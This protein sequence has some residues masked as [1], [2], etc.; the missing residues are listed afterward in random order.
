MGLSCSLRLTC[1]RVADAALLRGGESRYTHVQRSQRLT[2]PVLCAARRLVFSSTGDLTRAGRARVHKGQPSFVS[3]V[4][5]AAEGL[6][7]VLFPSDCRICG[8]PLVKISRLP[9]CDDCLTRMQPIVEPVCGTCGER[10]PGQYLIGQDGI[11]RCNECRDLEPL[12]AKAL[13]YGSYDSGLRELIHLLKYEQV[14]PAASVL[15]RMLAEAIAALRLPS[16]APPLAVPVPLHR[17]KLRQRGFNQSELIARA[18]L[19]LHPAG[20]EFE[21]RAQ[22]LQRVRSTLSQTGL[23][24]PQRVE[25]MRGAFAVKEDVSGR[26]VLLLDDV[27]TTGTTVSEC[28]RVLRRAGAHRVWV[29]TVARVLKVEAAFADPPM[30]E[31]EKQRPRAKALAAGV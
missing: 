30:E 11:A 18:A 1:P 27:F 9:V 29:A 21:L 4:G 20:R 23:T 7:T 15:G 16:G 2:E 13:A 24:R 22:A 26:D 14:R 12:F 5:T 25:N 3:L 8:T 17:D 10:L 31:E 6:F 19:K 28:A